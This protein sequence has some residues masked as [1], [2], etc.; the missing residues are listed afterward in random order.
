[1]KKGVFDFLSKKFH[2]VQENIGFLSKWRCTDHA[3]LYV[4]RGE[5]NYRSGIFNKFAWTKKNEEKYLLFGCASACDAACDEFAF[6]P[7]TP[8]K[9]TKITKFTAKKRIF[10]KT[11]KKIFN[12]TNGK[13]YLSSK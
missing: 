8:D 9:K 5:K 11:T 1:M 6:S 2:F 12:W 3:T 7:N 13:K 4:Q 10:D